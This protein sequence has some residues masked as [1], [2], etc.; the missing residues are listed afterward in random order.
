MKLSRRIARFNK[1]VNN[2]IQR[3]YAWLVPPWAII[4]HRGRRSGRSYRTPV[5]AFRQEQALVVALL[6]GEESDWFRN[7][8]AAGGGQVVRKGRTFELGEPRVVDTS[9]AT[10]LERLSPPA[11]AYCRLADKQVLA[12]IGKQLGGFGPGRAS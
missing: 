5:L 7:L 1:V 11:R 3:V 8:R 6:Y 12:E 9:T 10:E 4:L 2:R